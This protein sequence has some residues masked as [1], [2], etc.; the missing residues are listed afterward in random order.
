MALT[1]VIHFSL[2]EP[3][4]L[5]KVVVICVSA[6]TV[7]VLPV[8]VFFSCVY[9]LGLGFPNYLDSVPTS[10]STSCWNFCS[11]RRMFLLLRPQVEGS[12]LGA[13]PGQ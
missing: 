13:A 6:G 8:W 11:L 10:V 1:Q 3:H 4:V 12:F 5:W 9:I 7:G 2:V